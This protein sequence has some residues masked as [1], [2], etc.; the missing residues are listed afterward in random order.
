MIPI[1]AMHPHG[2]IARN[3]AF[4]SALSPCLLH[5]TM[6]LVVEVNGR[7]LGG[8]HLLIQF[9]AACMNTNRRNLRRTR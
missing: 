8:R 9:A 4:A 7:P 6:A 1:L 2:V 5:R 3:G